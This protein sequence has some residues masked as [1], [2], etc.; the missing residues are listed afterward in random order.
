MG[1]EGQ[2]EN[3]QAWRILNKKCAAI[4]LKKRSDSIVHARYAENLWVIFST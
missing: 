1:G 3:N 4:T 2:L